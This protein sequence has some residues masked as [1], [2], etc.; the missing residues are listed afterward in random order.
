MSKFVKNSIIYTAVTILQRA[1][2]F[3]LLPLYTNHL[4]P[5]DYGIVSVVNSI[6]AFLVIVLSLSI[7][8]AAGRYYFDYRK[9]ENQLKTFW[10][11][12]LVFLMSYSTLVSVVVFL[13]RKWLLE[14]IAPTIPFFPFMAYGLLAVTFNP[15]FLF[16]QSC[17]IA[18]QEGGTLAING[19]LNFL[20]NLLLT[21]YFVVSR[22]MGA[23]GV[24]LAQTITNGLF[25]FNSI[26]FLL[27]KTKLGLNLNYLLQGLKYSLPL[28]PHSLFGWTS[29]TIDRL[30][31]SKMRSIIEVGLYSVGFQFGQIIGIITDAINR[32]YAPW[33]L[34][35]IVGEIDSRSKIIEVTAILVSFYSILATGLSLFGPEILGLMTRG[36]FKTVWRILPILS[37]AYVFGGVYYVVCNSLF[38]KKTYIVPIVTFS[39]AL[40]TIL[41]NIVLIPRIGIIGA[42]LAN[43]LSQFLTSIITIIA[44]MRAEPIKFK[45]I[46]MYSTIFLGM[47][48]S[49]SVYVI[50][51]NIF[52][53]LIIKL[54]LFL[55]L[56]LYLIV[57]HWR[58][59]KQF[60]PSINIEGKRQP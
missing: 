20:L 30:F 59:I 5:T 57:K 45:W 42:A 21:L 54:L 35:K 38:I 52:I 4:T 36:D 39:S 25:C 49:S 1:T 44:S 23:E 50:R 51:G 28:V 47:I 37:F 18:Q 3:F 15:V 48:L 16:F 46:S 12:L 24:L 43:F 19:F 17:L 29:S 53:T 34:E 11:T 60:Y 22:K 58:F 14:P 10:G 32:A 41:C 13:L 26:L 40:I 8:G 56:I 2:S 9:D 7:N 27:P 33:F 55:L 6:T 31:I